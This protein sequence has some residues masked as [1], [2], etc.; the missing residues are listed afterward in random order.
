ML[1]TSAASHKESP[2][3]RRGTWF[4]SALCNI[5]N[6]CVHVGIFSFLVLVHGV[7]FSATPQH[8]HA[9]CN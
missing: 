7:P 6:W 8:Y 9:L 5:G 2:P 4:H 1:F 3:I